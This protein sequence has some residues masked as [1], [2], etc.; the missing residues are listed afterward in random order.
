M[1]EEVYAEIGIGNET[2]FSTEIEKAK[3]EY[4]IT[5]FIIPKKINGI[6]I[7]IWTLKKVLII[8]TYNGIKLKTKPKNKFKLIFGIEGI[9]K[10]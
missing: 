6:Y 3:E 5:K 4:R 9:G 7:R 8:S 1:K 2:F 10:K